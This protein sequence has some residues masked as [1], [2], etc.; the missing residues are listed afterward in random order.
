MKQT[1]YLL[2]FL[3]LKMSAFS[4]SDVTRTVCSG[5]NVTVTSADLGLPAGTIYTWTR[6]SFNPSAAAISNSSDELVGSLIFSQTLTNTTSSPADV[7]YAVTPSSGNPFNITINVNPVPFIGDQTTTIC[8]GATFYVSPS[9]AGVPIGTQY[10][11][12][13]PVQTAGVSGGTAQGTLQPSISQQLTYTGTA[14]GTATYTV[15][16]NASGC[17]GNTFKV[18]V[19]INRASTVPLLTSTLNPAPRCSGS[20]FTYNATSTPAGTTMAWSR[21]AIRGISNGPVNGN[22]GISEVLND[23]TTQPVVVGYVYT[24]TSTTGCTNTQVVSVTINPTPV[25]T[26]KTTTTC[27]GTPFNVTISDALPANTNFTW[28]APVINPA[29]SITGGSAQATATSVISQPLVNLRTTPGLATYNVTPIAGSGTSSCA[30]T[31][32]SVIVTI[33]PVPT[34]TAQQNVSTC[35]G[36]AFNL[37]PAAVPSGTTYTWAAPSINPTSGAITGGTAQAVAQPAI[38]QVLTNTTI[39]AATATYAVTPT[40][41]NCTGPNFNTVVT[42]NAAPT[43]SPQSQALTVCSGSAFLAPQSGVPTN[44][45]YSWGIPQVSPANALT[46]GIAR[47]GAAT[48]SQ[49]LTNVT[50]APATATYTITPSSGTCTGSSFTLVVTVNPTPFI[51]AQT[52]TSCSGNQFNVIPSNAPTGTT[53]TWTAPTMSAGVTGGTAQTIPQASISQTLIYTGTGNGTALYRVTPIAFGCTGNTFD[54]VDTIT[55]APVVSNVTGITCSGI[56]F[57]ITPVSSIGSTVYT[58]SVPVSNPAGSILG[59]TA[60]TIPQ[61]SITETLINNTAAIGTA[62]YTITPYALGCTGRPFTLTQTVNP[63]PTVLDIKTNVCS[64][65]TF[66]VSPPNTPVGTTYT[67]TNPVLTPTN[68]ITGNSAQAT[69]L[70]VITQ[71]LTNITSAPATATYTV[72]PAVGNCIGTP[73]SVEV[74]VNLSALL[75]DLSSTICSGET[76]DVRPTGVPAGTT[77]T[78]S[79]PQHSTNASGG[80]SQNVGQ[81]GISQTLTNTGSVN[82]TVV[83]A[84]TPNSAGCSGRT[85]NLTVNVKPLPIVPDLRQSDCSGTSFSATP[86]SN[87]PSTT[88]TW[89]TPLISPANSITG[90]LPRNSGVPTISQTLTNITNNVATATYSVTP[91]ANGCTGNPFIFIETVIPIPNISTQTTTSCSGI[92]FNVAPTNVPTGTTTVYTWSA[93]VINPVNSL[94]GG[95][96]QNSPLTVINQT[97]TNNTNAP[98]TATY[99]VMPLSGSCAGQQFAVVVTVTPKPD[100]QDQNTSICSGSAFNVLPNNAPAGTTYTWQTPNLS[101]GIVGGSNQM[102]PQNSISQVL[103]NTNSNSSTGTAT[104]AV[105]PGVGSCIG[106]VFTVTVSINSNSTV[107]SSSLTPPAVCSGT[108]FSYTPTSLSPGTAF[109]WSRDT[110]TGITNIP[111]TGYG[112]INEILFNAT[113]FPITVA[114]RFSLSTNGCTNLVSQFVR[115]VVNPAPVL[116]SAINPPAICSGT[117]FNYAATSNTF[118]VVFNWS[119]SYVVGITDPVTSGQGNISEVLNNPTY[120]A[121]IVPYIFTLTANGC[122]NIQTVYETVNSVL[123]VPDMN[124]ASCSG[125]SFSATAPNVPGGTL[126]LWGTPQ[127]SGGITGGSSQTLVAQPSISQTLIN[128]GTQTGTAAYVVTPVTPATYTSGCTGKTFILTVSVTPIPILSSS[129]TPPPVCSGSTF[130]YVPASSTPGT[131]FSWVR[132]PV[133]GISN[134]PSSGNAV[135]NEV[136]LNTTTAA[137]DVVYRLKLTANGCADTTQSITVKVNPAPI[138]PD[139]TITICSR[140]G[141]LLPSNLEPLRTTY[142]WGSPVI[143]P[144]GAISGFTAQTTTP[145]LSFTDTLTNNTITS[146]TATYTLLPGGGPCALPPFNVVVVVKPTSTIG[147]QSLTKCSGAPINFTPAGTPAGTSYTW[148]LPTYSPIYSVTGGTAQAIL[149][150]LIAQTLFN[151]TTTV[152]SAIYKVLPVTNGCVGDTFILTV[153]VNP[154][155]TVNIFGKAALCGNIPDT[156]SLQFTGTSPWSYIYTDTKNPFPVTVNGIASSPS[157]FIQNAFTAADTSYRFSILKITDAFC[158]N[159]TSTAT[160]RQRIYPLPYDTILAPNGTQICIG[161]TLPLVLTPAQSSYQWYL[162]D[163]AI[164]GAT[165]INYDADKPGSYAAKITNG[166]G[167]TNNSTNKITLFQ[168]RNLDIQY[169]FDNT[170][171]DVSMRFRNLT[172]TVSV[173]PIKWLW[174]FGDGDSS[175]AASPVHVYKTDGIRTVRVFATVGSC[176]DVFEKD[177]VILIR[178]AKPGIAL[179]T[180]STYINVNTPLTSRRIQGDT[181]Q[182]RW[183]PAFGLNNSTLRDPAFNFSQPQKYFVNMTNPAGCVTTD[184]LMVRVFDTGIVNIFVPSSFSPNRDGVNDVLYPYIA[185]IKEFRYFKVYNRYGQILFETRDANSGWDGTVNGTIQPMGAYVWVAEGINSNG[186]VINKNGNVLLLR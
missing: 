185:G 138:V 60:Q 22:N 65:N 75:P 183:F 37:A 117:F 171:S 181:F 166:L 52:N 80:S 21:P 63:T 131:V 36:V 144:A 4:Q 111:G 33:N 28:T 40:S 142:N 19:T 174:L 12:S 62:T 9:T 86:L 46:G 184:T 177:S 34:I 159:D 122:T 163:T 7:E 143:T 79:S 102:V 56:G 92:A 73:F 45:L 90:A 66:N 116:S 31:A 41:G 168:I 76:F 126:Y 1:A 173:G 87:L 78:W 165:N 182:Y 106:N 125:T 149:Q 127:Q 103:L 139:Q 81:P 132:N 98:A 42:V 156:L 167:C 61:N 100:I 57:S 152:A 145:Q 6:T 147:M 30:G 72:T 18:T 43:I 64:G 119:R 129:K 58:W 13:T 8:S 39:T 96:A 113:P 176:N 151:P 54:V 118:N 59:G 26:P 158:L 24:L 150:Q 110:T 123:T 47:T 91:T 77:Y 68:S 157:Q 3:L 175:R 17:V 83:Y 180:V 20:N 70:S 148:Q 27:S 53:Y 136:L 25:V 172:N 179:P 101:N 2:L 133:T 134:A 99:S 155:P 84:V 105:T 10:T 14:T 120:N 154:L 88:Y 55:A 108:A 170:C 85:F 95:S 115:V 16:P 51:N 141:F 15:T 35:S 121:V 162:N 153:N 109:T 93:P 50:N 44:T 94:T 178:K 164:A 49:T 67:W 140:S 11:W 161:G 74:L 124:I 38:N 69:P 97:L 160:I 71:N 114:Y 112:N 23:T 48:V 146:A 104:Y 128:I 89:T 130:N 5:S 32:F 169:T 82:G 137:I 107:L 29:G 186:K 135:I